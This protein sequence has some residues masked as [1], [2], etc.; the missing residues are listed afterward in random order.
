LNE[1]IGA[2]PA[3]LLGRR[4]LNRATLARQMLLERARSSARDAIE[5]LVGMQSQIPNDP[6]VG[7][8]TR[9][10][11]FRQEEL[12]GLIQERSAVRIHLMR[13]TIHLV[14]DRDVARLRPLLQPALEQR[15]HRGS[16][17]GRLLRQSGIDLDEL[18][19][20]GRRL[21][22]ERPM[23]IV[24]LGSLLGERFPQHD[25]GSMARAVVT[26]VPVVQVPPRGVW[27][28]GGRATWFSAEK[29]LGGPLDDDPS[30]EDMVMRY[31]QAYG[32]AS[33]MDAQAWCGLTRLREVVDRLRPRLVSF[34][35]EDDREV[36][37]LPNAPR[38]D[39]DTPVPVRFLPV[40]DN[41]LLGHADRSRLMSD[42][43]RT[44]LF[45]SGTIGNVGSVLVDG[46]VKALWRLGGDRRAAMLEIEPIERLNKKDLSAVT[47]EGS[48][49]LDFVA[50]DADRRD[51]RTV[52]IGTNLDRRR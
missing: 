17:F 20:T 45:G 23:T 39:P 36:F 37:D 24:E 16:P 5:R 14:T 50:S 32:P 43:A 8:W 40:F 1:G 30:P 41:I 49:L 12:A 13:W 34:R 10:K 4:A 31:L 11:D 2:R 21:V 9:L 44:R 47:S 25:A 46:T 51:I 3:P 28:A 35:D 29:W 27:G 26:S 52:P 42:E 19:S 7:L 33:V 15:F 6:Y 22:E 38:P 48:R 18:V